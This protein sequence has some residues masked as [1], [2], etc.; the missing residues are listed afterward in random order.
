M[1]FSPCIAISFQFR[2][3]GHNKDTTTTTD[4][5]RRRQHHATTCATSQKATSLQNEETDQRQEGFQ[6]GPTETEGEVSYARQA[7]PQCNGECVCIVG[8]RC[9]AQIKNQKKYLKS[10]SATANS[11]HF[12]TYRESNGTGRIRR[13]ATEAADGEAAD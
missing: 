1:C 3:H 9:I 12:G 11:V 5:G 7:R 2:N 4:H 10:D 13:M 6:A 8:G